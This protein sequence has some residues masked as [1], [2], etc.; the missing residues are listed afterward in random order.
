MGKV[1][2]LLLDSCGI[3]AASDAEKFGDAGADTLG[4]I[5]D[6]MAKNRQDKTGAIK[7]LHLP[8]LA[9]CGLEKAAELSRGK[10]LVHPLG[11]D[12]SI[13]AAYTYAEEISK[14]KDTLSGH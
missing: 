9:T 10:A 12:V 6:W 4:H 11:D 3:G 2:I 5:A 13:Q 14:G 8:N 1:T 7:Y